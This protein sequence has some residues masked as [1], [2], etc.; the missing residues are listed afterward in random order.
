LSR[1]H[2]TIDTGIHGSHE[3]FAG[4]I[5]PTLDYHVDETGERD[6]DALDDGNGH[7]WVYYE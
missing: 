6:G 1:S 4:M 5:N 3:D 2:R 7:G